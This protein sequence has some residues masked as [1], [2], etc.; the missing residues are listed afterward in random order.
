MQIT[1]YHIQGLKYGLYK[2]ANKQH[3]SKTTIQ[4]GR[5]IDRKPG[6][7]IQLHS[8]FTCVSHRCSAQT[9]AS[10]LKVGAS[11]E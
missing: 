4:K 8:S 11:C 6:V 5:N 2:A 9:E 3:N 1:L 10:Q 7:D